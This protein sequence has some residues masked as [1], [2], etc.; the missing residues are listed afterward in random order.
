MKPTGLELGTVCENEV[1]LR[2]FGHVTKL[3]A[4]EGEASIESLIG[5]LRDPRIFGP[6]HDWTCPCGKYIDVEDDEI[7][8][9]RCGVRIGRARELRRIRFGHIRFPEPIPHPFLA[10]EQLRAIPVIP[11]GY[12]RDTGARDLDYL[13]E[14][15]LRANARWCAGD[16]ESRTDLA[17]SVARL[18][19]N[20]HCPQPSREA[21]RLVR[22]LSHFLC[23]APE[24]SLSSLGT[25]LFAICLQPK[26]WDEKEAI[27]GDEKVSG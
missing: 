8:C 7:V 10:D 25:Y 24:S 26:L 11:I 9:D 22:S 20:E 19:A 4:P 23:E 6:D 12:R 5:S 3:V 2:S 17:N 1:L 18:F 21:G 16:T 15:V 13:Y 14:Q 27:Q